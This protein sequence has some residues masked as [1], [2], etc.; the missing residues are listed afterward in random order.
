VARSSQVLFAA[1]VVLLS[2]LLAPSLSPAPTLAATRATTTGPDFDGD[3]FADLAIGVP[4]EGVAGAG[5]AGAVEVLYGSSGGLAPHGEQ[6]WTQESGIGNTPSTGDGFGSAVATGDFDDDGFSDL[7]VGVPHDNLGGRGD[8]GEVDVL[9]GSASGLSVTGAQVWTLNTGGVPGEAAAGDVFGESVAGGDF[10]RDGFT[11][12][13]IGAPGNDIGPVHN[14]GS[15]TVIPGS[16]TGLTDRGSLTLSQNTPGVFGTPERGDDMGW[17]LA[18]GDVGRD[19]ADDLVVGNPFDNGSGVPDAGSVAILYGSVGTGVVVTG[20]QLLTQN[21]TGMIGGA[22]TGDLFGWDVVA[23][24]LGGTS[25]GDLAV[26]VPLEDRDG[27]V[28]VGVVNVVYGSP[29]GLTTEGN[30][31]WDEDATQTGGFGS[32]GDEFG[33][34]LAIAD[35]GGTAR[36]DL[37]IG[38]SGHDVGTI[39]DAGQAFVLYGT[40]D[41]LAP[42]GAQVWTEA[43]TQNQ[44]GPFHDDLFG[45]DLTAG[46]Y[47]GNGIADLT[48]GVVLDDVGSIVNAGGIVAIY[49]RAGGLDGAGA[50]HW[51][52]GTGMPLNPPED[53]DRYGFAVA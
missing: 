29:S 5:N 36:G 50:Q 27:K 31:A 42:G 30:Q 11:D 6:F 28:D 17:A 53:G 24:K 43:V 38:S 12:L 15:V 45:S 35:F 22:E 2:T 25:E 39:P 23:G 52:E 40:V 9:Y 21:T 14:A 33:N 26:G 3:G 48:V 46:D 37:A 4:G 19:G 47:D 1:A 7:A 10:D 41:G 51:D 32:R 16:A 44:N 8:A 34:A 18:A 20:N 49:G 13:A